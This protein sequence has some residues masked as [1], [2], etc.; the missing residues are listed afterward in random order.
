MKVLYI[1]SEGL[2]DRRV[3]RVAQTAK[4]EGHC[5]CFVGPF[6]E[7]V[8]IPTFPFDRFYKMP[9]NKL[10][11][12][13][14]PSYW[15]A[16]K[17][18][19]SRI[20]KEYNPDLIHAHNI[21]SAKLASEFSIPFVYDDHE[22][23]SKNCRARGG[24]WKPNKIYRNW[25]WTRWEKSVI[26]GASAV[27]VTC[28]TVAE[29]HKLLNNEVYVVSN[30]PLRNITA[31]LK[32]N[33]KENKY[34]SSVYLGGDCSNPSLIPYRNVEGLTDLFSKNNVGKLV[35]IGDSQL[36]SS[37]NVESLGFLPHRMMM[38]KLT[39]YQIGLL[40]WKKHWLHKY[41]NP[42]KPYEYAH[43][44][45]IV[46]TTSDFPCV[47]ERLGKFAVAFDNLS[48]L[49]ELLKYYANNLDELQELRR[50]TRKFALDNLTWEKN[51][52]PP[53]K[54]AYSKI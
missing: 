4:G 44:G 3:E 39:K 14:V 17:R 16:L 34:L 8:I 25:L 47:I 15:S 45:L 50:K 21:V 22:Y 32:P 41:N 13:K 10:A 11:N 12:V 20:I 28:E 54:N 52:E 49:K 37:R 26:K 27:I 40:P 43:A 29:E 51:C 18:K 7:G 31:S 38:E 36:P 19:L 5:T 42:N 30:L 35:V 48:E 53:I 24:T 33:F 9:F 2:P 6:K 1:S 23:W 46:L